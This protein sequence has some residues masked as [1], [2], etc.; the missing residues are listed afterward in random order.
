MKTFILYSKYAWRSIKRGGQRS[1]FAILCVAVGVSAIVALQSTGAA[2]QD[3]IAGDAR[4]SARAD[5]L[6][7]NRQGSFNQDDLAKLD[8][9]KQNATIT[10][11]TS[12]ITASIVVT[13]ADG[14]KSNDFNSTYAA[15]VVD[16]AKYPFYGN[17]ELE[18]PKDKTFNQVLNGPDQLVLNKKMAKSIGVQ[19]G[20]KIRLSSQN[21][22]LEVQVVGLLSDKVNA[23]PVDQ[24]QMAE[25]TGYAFTNKTTASVL[26]SAENLKIDTVYVKTSDTAGADV[27]ARDAIKALSSAFAADTATERNATL[28][29]ASSQI[30]DMLSYVGL[31]S[32]LIGSVG[33]VNT[34]LVVVGR[35]STEIATIKALGMESGQT[36]RV[37][38]IES[39]ILGF[40]GSLSG[41]VLGELLTLGTSRAAEGFINRSIDYHFYWQPVIIGL[42][43]GVATAV[44]FGL[45][46]AYSAS[47]IPPAQVLRQKTTALPRISIFATLPIIVVMTL[48]MG[49]IA[50]VILDGNY[51]IGI[52]AAFGTLVACA[53]LVLVFSGILALVGKLPLPF[54]LSY[55]M[56][57]RNLSRGRAKSAVTMLVMMVGIFSMAL[58]IILASSLKDTV[59]KTLEDSLGYNTVVSA[60]DAQT[61]SLIKGLEANRIPGQEKYVENV[62]AQ[63]RLLSVNGVSYD[64][65]IQRKLAQQKT[66]G[67]D[68]SDKYTGRELAYLD[69]FNS[70]DLQP[71]TRKVAGEYYSGDGQA[72]VLESV[73]EDYGIKIGD[74]LVYQDSKGGNE[75]T[76]T[77]TGIT[78]NKNQFAGVSS[79]ATTIGTVRRVAAHQ[80]QLDIKIDKARIDEAKAYIEKNYQSAIVQDLSFITNIFDKLIDNLTAFPVLLAMLS[81]IAGA[82]L[83]ANNVALAVLERRTEMGVMKSIGA[84]SSKVLSIINWETAIVSLLGALIGFGIAVVAAQLAVTSF[85]SEDHPG[86]LT[87]SPLLFIGMLVLAVGMSLVATIGSAW[88]AVRE[89][90]L[91][92]LR[93]E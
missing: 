54:G 62:Q 11:Y 18:S 81:L 83:I 58:V 85:S 69:G 59:K 8:T 50:G 39:A 66:N 5:V 68:Q 25:F 56:A 34:M 90:P 55:K 16:P 12:S 93:Y 23:P 63:V 32:L 75:F 61:D 64:E 49:I 21:K 1:F 71:I 33:V 47:K 3:A 92:V 51:T 77:I 35:R 29:K 46:P 4:A 38:V 80:N 44:V 53:V 36:V 40:L 7:T 19:V 42:I 82:V 37:F 28:K 72:V 10:D 70:Q 22:T 14:S 76:L 2:I 43:V 45:L 67:N 84:D 17:E 57:R 24:A 73:S 65:L 78:R 74:K 31:L 9:L 88:S 52:A 13:K 89:K 41:L 79:V 87:V 91:V 15:I 30:N 26:F 27:K 86:I 6:V 20:D 48:L 60:G